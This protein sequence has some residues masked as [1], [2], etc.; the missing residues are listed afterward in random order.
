M[1]AAWHKF[2]PDVKLKIIVAFF[3]IATQIDDVYESELV[4]LYTPYWNLKWSRRNSSS[5][6]PVV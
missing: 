1:S 6:E 5:F 4:M 2:S 3:L